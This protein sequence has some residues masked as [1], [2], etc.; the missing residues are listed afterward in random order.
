MKKD[1]Y[2]K[3]SNFYQ[4]AFLFAKG[5]KLV[6]IDRTDSKRCLF[7][8]IDTPEREELLRFFNFGKED[9]QE[10][11]VDGRKIIAAIKILKDKLYQN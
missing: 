1:K 8:F 6:D 9:A 5:L 3:S 7:V 4:S 10:V 11:M 2:F